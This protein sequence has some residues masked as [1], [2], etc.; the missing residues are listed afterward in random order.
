MR[1]LNQ[2][3]SGVV[4]IVLIVVVVA[5]L[6]FTGWFVYDSKKS[7]DKTTSDAVSA[8]K[9]GASSGTVVGKVGDPCTLVG[10]VQGSKYSGPANRYSF[11]LPDGWQLYMTGGA[12][13]SFSGLIGGASGL[14]YAAG[15]KGKVGETGGKDG[16]FNFMVTYNKP[17]DSGPSD[18]SPA[19]TIQA[20]NATGKVSTYTQTTE[21]PEGAGTLPK[22]TVSTDYY[23]VKDGA[24]LGI[25]YNHFPTDTADVSELVKSV[26][27]S[28]ELN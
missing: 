15:T 21:P 22:G 6:G 11:C 25:T 16:A 24:S 2:S 13:S 5:I 19:G 17:A 20:V 27:Q 4:E 7:V 3:G 9:P 8:T 28:V 12:D 10:G 26:A 23:F 1:K 14:T 18:Y